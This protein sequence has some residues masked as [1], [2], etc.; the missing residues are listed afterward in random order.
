MK[1]ATTCKALGRVGMWRYVALPVACL[2]ALPSSADSG[3]P[4]KANG[5]YAIVERI[6]G[7]SS[8]TGWDEA[9]VDGSPKRLFLATSY[10]SGAGVTMLDLSSGQA[11]SNFVAAKRPHGFAIVAGGT[12][13]VSDAGKNAVLFFDEATGKV[14]ASVGTGKP[15]KPEGWQNPDAL[16]LE[17]ATGL[18]VAVNHDSGALA[19][20]DVSRHAVVGSIEIGGE[21]EGIDAKG[22]GTVYV[23]VA[24]ANA[25]AVVNLPA[26]KLI[27]K[28]ALKGCEEPTGLAFDAADGLIISVC[29]NG[30]A[31]FVDPETG[32]E[33]ASVRVGKGADGVMY[34]PRRKM[35]FVAGGDEGT[36]SVIRL[37]DRN[38]VVLT[39][40][41]GTQPGTRLG[42]VDPSTGRL[43][44]PTAKPDL[45]APP[46]RLPGLPPFPP[47]LSGSFEF[48]VV[49]QRQSTRSISE[50]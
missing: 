29:S 38:H 25:I 12:A 40:T 13:A 43:Y 20:V 27:R 49:T 15:P 42:V 21:L 24:S 26:R 5:E 45:K 18:L 34:D 16:L 35:V 14:V 46:V 32:S 11:T 22:D 4:E 31:K 2:I 30:L 48:L 36:L 7:P 1:T 17:P 8:V 3:A 23:N 47:A 19:L 39:Q 37:S 28:L 10:S 9:A 44:L 41:L 50:P 33:L 6:P